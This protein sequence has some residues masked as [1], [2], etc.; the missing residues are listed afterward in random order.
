MRPV[1]LDLVA[2]RAAHTASSLT[3]GEVLVAGGCVVDGCGEATANTFIVA[4]DGSSARAGPG[5]L[6][7]RDSHTATVIRGDV[8]LAGGFSGEGVPPLATVDVYRAGSSAI[9]PF[10]TLTQ[11]RGGHAAALMGDGSTALVAGGWIRS[12]TYASSVEIL[13][14]ALGVVS[15]PDLPWA[16]DALDAVTLADGRVLVTGGQIAP[17]VATDAAAIYDRAAA[18][19]R[20]VGPLTTARLKHSSVL[21]DDGRVFIF[22][23][24][25]DDERLLA[26]TELFD[27]VTGTFD[28]GPPLNEPR[29]KMPGGAVALPNG[30]VLIGGGG[31]T[32][33]LVDVPNA[34]TDVVAKL[35]GRDSF[36]TLSALADDAYIVLGGYDERINLSRDYT[37]VRPTD[38]GG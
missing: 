20:V 27:P 15:A 22:G 25:P 8:Y 19:W 3:S 23:G 14:P 12:R 17:G 33:E 21:L 29:Y 2:A 11:A 4:G 30:R 24:S 1:G 31:R 5:M 26:T 6:S 34:T 16:A 9:E 38:A 13:D 7:P 18:S 28:V 37:V 35:D 10:G 32:V 36:G